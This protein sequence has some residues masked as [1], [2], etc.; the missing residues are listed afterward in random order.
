MIHHI[1]DLT[2]SRNGIITYYIYTIM[3]NIMIN[4]LTLLHKLA[5]FYFYQQPTLQ[6]QDFLT[7][8]MLSQPNILMQSSH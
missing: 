4:S 8:L 6:P 5:S 2:T 3:S 1:T 7:N